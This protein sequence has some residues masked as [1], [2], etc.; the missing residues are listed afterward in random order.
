MAT[1]LATLEYA[2][3]TRPKSGESRCG[4]AAW[5]EE[6]PRGASFA[7]VDGLGYGAA[8]VE[9]ADHAVATLR[10]HEGESLLARAHRCHEV[11]IGSR[12]ASLFLAEMDGDGGFLSWVGIGQIEALLIPAV[13][14]PAHASMHLL[15]FSGVVGERLPPL[16]VQVAALRAGDCLVI[17]SHGLA[18]GFV[19]EA[20]V[21]ASVDDLAATLLEHFGD[22]GE[23]ALVLV[24][25]WFGAGGHGGAQGCH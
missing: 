13:R 18:P 22:R 5:V 3:L 25:R 12:G 11:L 9:A 15:N 17:A 2:L 21:P 1:C 24:V 16:Q 8:T 6:T 7:V 23:D 19:A 14:S 4:N 20:R 10:E